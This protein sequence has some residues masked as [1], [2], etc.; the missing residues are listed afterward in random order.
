MIYGMYL[1]AS[2]SLT[3][4]ARQDVAANN[5]ANVDTVGFKPDAFMIRQR[6]AVRPEDGL[7]HLDSNAMLERLGGGVMPMP[8]RVVA[9]SAPLRDTGNPLDVAI[10]GSG[11]LA[12]RVGDG[13][14]SLRVTRDGR[15][16]LNAQ[17]TLVRATDGSPV[18]GVGGSPIRLDPS[19]PVAIDADGTIRQN[20]EDVAQLMLVDVPQSSLI[21]AGDNLMRVRPDADGNRPLAPAQGTVRQH[22][23]EASG[24]DPIKALMAVNDAANAAQTNL[25][26]VGLFNDI[27]DRAINRLGRVA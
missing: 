23:V 13:P 14:D 20:G 8:T 18:L 11:F 21:K 19:I 5:L 9:A 3:Q 17:G 6:E 2:G 15:M 10:E 25:R 26:M 12:V 1:S 4:M 7:Y 16:T 27:M 22:F 24:V